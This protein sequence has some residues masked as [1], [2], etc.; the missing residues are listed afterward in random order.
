MSFIGCHHDRRVTLHDVCAHLTSDRFDEDREAVIERARQAG[1]SRIITVSS[2]P[3]DAEQCADL[4]SLYSFIHFTAG[5]HPHEAKV[6]N[7]AAAEALR[8]AVRRPK[9]VAI[10]EIGLDYHYDHSPRETQR[11]VFREQ[12]GL[13]RDLGLPI[14]IHTREAWDDTFTILE[15]ERAGEIGGVFHCFSGGPEE[16]KRCLALDFYLSFAGPVTF[17]NAGLLPEA[18]MAAPLDRLLI[19]YSSGTQ[20][21]VRHAHTSAPESHSSQLQRLSFVWFDRSLGCLQRRRGLTN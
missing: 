7:A 4:A 1:L 8:A 2:Y 9:A 12:I 3:G 5:V 10:G 18:A 17:K 13:A 20:Q 14:V 16:A 19:G 21:E 11:A 15:E 6:W